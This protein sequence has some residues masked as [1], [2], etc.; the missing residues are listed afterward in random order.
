MPQF[1]DFSKGLTKQAPRVAYVRGELA[2]FACCEVADNVRVTENGVSTAYGYT[3]VT[4]TPF[5]TRPRGLHRYKRDTSPAFDKMLIVADGKLWQAPLDSPTFTQVAGTFSTSEKTTATTFGSDCLLSNAADGIRKFD[6][7]ALSAITFL[8][9]T[10]P[11]FNSATDRPTIMAVRDDRIFFSGCASKP[12]TVFTPKPSTYNDFADNLADAFDVNVGDGYGV[13]GLY[14]TTNGNL[15]IFKPTNIH[16]LSG[17]GPSDSPI[18]PFIINTYSRETGLVATDAI[19]PASSDL[20]FLSP[21]GLK[22]LGYVKDKGGAVYNTLQDTDPLARIQSVFDVPDSRVFA[23]ASLRF[24]RQTQELYLS[25]PTGA[26]RDTYTYYLKT[27]GI[28]RRPDLDIDLQWADAQGHWFTTVN[29]PYHLY[30]FN[31]GY[32]A[33]NV[34]YRCIWQSKFYDGG[35][36]DTRKCFEKLAIYYRAAPAA[37]SQVSIIYRLPDGSTLNETLYSVSAAYNDVWDVGTW[38]NTRWDAVADVVVRK[39]RLLKANAIAI[40]ITADSTAALAFDTISVETSSRRS[41]Q[42]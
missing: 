11:I 12:Y 22:R 38:D 27:Q 36:S 2:G 19:Q 24:N 32:T 39:A 42:R 18:D 16:V 6:G 23:E 17:A 13:N 10:T 3:A 31:T 34:P 35:T 8:N 14:A 26:K 28:A 41:N 4:T 1:T 30:K 5:A 37:A 33:N 25:L 9:P 20:Y 15:I 21:T 7:T 29:P 40:R